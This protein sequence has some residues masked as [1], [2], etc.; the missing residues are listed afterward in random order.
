MNK[1]IIF[2]LLIT[3]LT[4]AQEP[5]KIGNQMWVPYNLKALE[6]IDESGSTKKLTYIDLIAKEKWHPAAKRGEKLAAYT[7]AKKLFPGIKVSAW[8]SKNALEDALCN[9]A[10]F[11]IATKQDWEELILFLGGSEKAFKKIAVQDDFAKYNATNETGLSITPSSIIW[12]SDTDVYDENDNYKGKI[13]QFWAKDENSDAVYIVDMSDGKVR[14]LPLP[15]SDTGYEGRPCRCVKNLYKADLFGTK[16]KVSKDFK[17][18]SNRRGDS[19]KL[20]YSPDTYSASKLRI[21]WQ[22]EEE[23]DETLNEFITPETGIKMLDMKPLKAQINKRYNLYGYQ[24]TYE[25]SEGTNHAILLSGEIDAKPVSYTAIDNAP[26]QLPEFLNSHVKIEIVK[27]N[28]YTEG[29]RKSIVENLNFTGLGYGSD[30]KF[31][32]AIQVIEKAHKVKSLNRPQLGRLAEYCYYNKNYDKAIKYT[33]LGLKEK[34]DETL[35]YY[36]IY[37]NFALKDYA[38]AEKDINEIFKL[39]PYSSLLEPSFQFFMDGLKD[40][41]KAIAHA[42]RLIKLISP[43]TD[44]ARDKMLGIVYY[45]K[46]LAYYYDSNKAEAYKA[47]KQAYDHNKEKFEIPLGQA[48]F[49]YEQNK[50]SEARNILKSLIEVYGSNVKAL[51]DIAE[52]Y[53]LGGENEEACKLIKRTRKTKGAKE[54]KK[55]INDLRKKYCN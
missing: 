35:Y 12:G 43:R 44:S 14:V 8:Y 3:S 51:I 16:I 39:N 53:S 29:N 26:V 10:G 42:D 49:L 30:Q 17:I 23:L 38:N 25:N 31:N 9:K 22:V 48:Q 33:S 1:I 15:S 54:F 50:N 45:N 41:K 18:G 13:L 5:V 21:E 11:H 27:E 34:A 20:K 6:Y 32:E 40:N 4:Y 47:M 37:S 46:S 7:F 2:S 28:D 19:Y 52:I 36:R 24:V 55:E